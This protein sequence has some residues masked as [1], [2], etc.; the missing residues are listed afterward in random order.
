MVEERISSMC[1][2]RRGYKKMNSKR[3]SIAFVPLDVQIEF[4]PLL[5]DIDILTI[6]YNRR[7]RSLFRLFYTQNGF[8]FEL[9]FLRW[10]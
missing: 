9:F 1:N 3:F 5:L 7:Y 2:P 10:V 4:N 8:V 6:G